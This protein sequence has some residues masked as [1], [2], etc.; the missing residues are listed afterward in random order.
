M[1]PLQEPPH[2]Y[3]RR[4]DCQHNGAHEPHDKAHDA[5]ERDA[6]G[7]RRLGGV[8]EIEPHQ[9]SRAHLEER[10]G[11]RTRAKRCGLARLWSAGVLLLALATAVMFVAVYRIEGG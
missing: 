11:H 4:G 10:T 5:R 8:R 1:P 2:P 7:A 3:R 9:T 6:V